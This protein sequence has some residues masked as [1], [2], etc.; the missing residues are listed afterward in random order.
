MFPTKSFQIHWIVYILSSSFRLPRFCRRARHW[1][2]A[3]FLF[4]RFCLKN[5]PYISNPWNA[6]YSDIMLKTDFLRYKWPADCF[7][8][9]CFRLGFLC[10]FQD[11]VTTFFGGVF[12]TGHVLF[13]VFRQISQRRGSLFENLQQHNRFVNSHPSSAHAHWIWQGR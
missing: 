5:Q 2:C 8:S 6:I 11:D 1:S 4:L 7:C 13:D 9:C 10:R 3:C 12:D